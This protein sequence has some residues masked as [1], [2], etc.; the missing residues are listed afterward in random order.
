MSSHNQPAFKKNALCLAVSGCVFISCLS[1]IANAL[2]IEEIVVTSQKR[3]QSTNDVGMSITALSGDTLKELSIDD[4]SDLAI[5]TPGLNYSDSG[6]GTPVY[7]M[8]GVGFNEGS[9]QATSTVGI[10]NDEVAVPF[11]IMSNGPMMDVERV[12]VMKGPQGTLFGRNST[13]GAINYIA[14]KP[15]EVFE[16]GMTFG[17]GNYET[18]DAEGFVSGSIS[19]AVRARLAFKTTQ[20]N[21]GWQES[22]SS[23]D[24]LGEKDKTGV[25]LLVEAD[26]SENVDALLSLNWWADKSDTIAPQANQRAWQR[27]SNTAVVNKIEEYWSIDSRDDNSIADWT[28]N[29]DFS[30]DHEQ[31]AAS[32][33]LNWHINDD[34]TLTSLS[35]FSNF[36]DHGSSHSRDGWGGAPVSDPEI[37]DLINNLA[38]ANGYVPESYLTNSGYTIVAD[39]NAFSQELRLSG[40]NDTVTWL[41]GAYYS[42]D[43]V[44]STTRLNHDLASN[45]NTE[46][47][48]GGFQRINYFTDQEGESISVFAHTEWQLTDQLNLTV[49]ARQSHDEIDFE[50]CSADIYGDMAQ[51]FNGIFGTDTQQGECY[52]ILHDTDP[53]VSGSRPKNLN[54]DSTSAKL[55]LNYFLNED[56][57]LYTSYSRGFKSGSFPTLAASTDL[58]LEPVVQEKLIALEVGVKATLFD[59]AAQFNAAAFSYD[60]T[61]KQMLTK[62]PSAFGSV[63]ILANIPES[64]IN[65][66]EFELQSSPMDGLFLSLAGSYLETEVEEFTGY[67]QTGLTPVDLSGSEFPF[68]P[69]F[70]FTALVN[71]EHDISDNLIASI[72]ADV[73]YSGSTQSDYAS[74]EAPLDPVFELD[75]Y[76]LLGLRA[77]L[78]AADDQWSLILWGRNVTDEFYANNTMKSTDSILRF[79]GMPATYGL[80][81]SYNWF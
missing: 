35:G 3:E 30:R 4:V 43:K 14:N 46:G 41:A 68:T 9:L 76:T 1:P 51:L 65:G 2:E 39:I 80:T 45:T 75:S 55:G 11:P 81:F 21:E 53:L 5:V 58:S 54:E 28:R 67:T 17:V 6:S 47:G 8:R 34:L 79:N 71:Y 33:T 78:R 24:T 32:L 60:Y 12:E 7:T 57:M 10:Y 72:G 23:N 38:L 29:S 61:N 42:T 25:R 70:Q 50:G 22:V 77:G 27:E 64:K 26:L 13:G 62:T 73:S 66:V 15:T 19:D 31:K 56:V 49:A 44:E 18:Y 69:E 20:S 36:K 59:G 40:S 63:F 52:T 48:V 37:E 74:S 16:A